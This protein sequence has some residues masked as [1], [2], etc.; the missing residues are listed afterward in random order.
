M[1]TTVMILNAVI[2]FQSSKGLTADG[3]VGPA[4]WNALFNSSSSSSGGNFTWW[5]NKV[6]IDAG[7]GG[8][9]PGAVGNGLNEKNVVLNIAK[10]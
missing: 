6:F 5:I 1:V 4:T 8:T 10:N 9:D 3:E 7:H 2:S